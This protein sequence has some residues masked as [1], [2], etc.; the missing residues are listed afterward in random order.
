MLRMWNKGNTYIL[1]LGVQTYTTLMEIRMVVP[2]E[3]ENHYLMIQ[4]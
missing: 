2:Q 1:M 3:D 4:L